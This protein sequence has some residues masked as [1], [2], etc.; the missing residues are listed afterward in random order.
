MKITSDRTEIKGRIEGAVS[1]QVEDTAEVVGGIV[2]GISGQGMIAGNIREL[3]SDGGIDCNVFIQPDPPETDMEQYV[4]Y[5]TYPVGHAS[6][7]ELQTIWT[8][9]IE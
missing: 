1:G 5:E 4:W 9:G 2:R 3:G 7:G 6:E 8:F